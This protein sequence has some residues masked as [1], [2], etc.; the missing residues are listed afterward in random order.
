[1]IIHAAL[2]I[3]VAAAEKRTAVFTFDD[4]KNQ[5]REQNLSGLHAFSHLS[6]RDGLLLATLLNELPEGRAGLED[7]DLPV[8]TFYS[9]E[10]RRWF[11]I[12]RYYDTILLSFIHALADLLLK[13]SH[14]DR[15]YIIS[16]VVLWGGFLRAART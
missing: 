6:Q 5:T 4:G 10:K 13:V 11:T 7:H 9:D 15:L 16:S 3:T 14:A 1:M 2:R 12:A 8:L